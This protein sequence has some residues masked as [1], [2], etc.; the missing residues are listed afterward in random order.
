[1]NQE[2]LKINI[3]SIAV[4]GFLILL[5]GVVLYFFRDYVS[6]NVR[7]FMPLPPLAVAA[8]IFVF[9]MYRHYGGALPSEIWGTVKEI[10]YSTAIATIAFGV[11]TILLIVIIDYVK[12]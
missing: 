7:F 1:M 4:A 2:L 8:Y 6:D 10:L 5:T 9:N 12:R 11:F 3:L